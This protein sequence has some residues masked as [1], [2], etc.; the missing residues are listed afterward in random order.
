MIDIH[1]H[2]KEVNL[3]IN[4]TPNEILMLLNQQILTTM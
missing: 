4:A 2:Q 1:E 3:K